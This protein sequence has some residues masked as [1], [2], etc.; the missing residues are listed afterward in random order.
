MRR[1]HL[2]A[3]PLLIAAAS[4]PAQAADDLL[5]VI[6]IGGKDCGPCVLWRT[7]SYPKWRASPEYG[8]VRYVDIEPDSLRDAYKSAHWPDGLGSIRSAVSHIRA[9]PRFVLARGRKVILTDIG[10]AGW[11]N[12]YAATRHALG[13]G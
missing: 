3:T 1:R 13:T 6:Y 10:G 4:W 7:Y 11:Q 8:R 12:V 9:T 5:M 2:L